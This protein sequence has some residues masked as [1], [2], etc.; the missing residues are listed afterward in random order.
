MGR[1]DWC[2]NTNEFNNIN[3]IISNLNYFSLA[4]AVH[5]LAE[6]FLSSA[7]GPDIGF[8]ACDGDWDYVKSLVNSKITRENMYKK[9]NTTRVM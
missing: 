1:Y 9:N 4:P 8:V 3:N 7:T 2:I 6:G 5:F